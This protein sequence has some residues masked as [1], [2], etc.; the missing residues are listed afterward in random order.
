[1]EVQIK[2]KEKEIILYDE[3]CWRCGSKKKP[4]LTYHHGIPQ[5]LK[6]MYNVQIRVCQKC[7]NEINATDTRGHLIALYKIEK[8][9]KVVKNLFYK[10]KEI[11][12]KNGKT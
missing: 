8:M 10:N 5:R 12:N 3:L 9:L 2:V 1:M 11:E 6:P 7:H 4:L